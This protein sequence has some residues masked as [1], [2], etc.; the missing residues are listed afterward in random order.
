M[1]LD[2]TPPGSPY[3]NLPEV[4]TFTVTSEDI[5]DGE[6]MDK[7]HVHD[8]AGGQNLSPQLS[9]SGFPAAT[10]SFAIT[11]FDPDAPTAS[12]WWH[13]LL[14]DLPVTTT[15]LPRGAGSPDGSHLPAGAVQFRTDYGSDGY[16]GCGPPP[17]DHPHRYLFV[18]H[19]LDV[20][21]LGL[22]PDTPAAIVGFHL[23]AHAVGRATIAGTYR[24]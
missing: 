20:P 23:T 3:D 11:C 18:V 4:P 9:W 16:Q 1:R 19:A 8:S 5:T 2:R 10:Q 14:A 6:P 12:G 21:H 13:W 24:H 15:S 22:A 17:G 7:Q